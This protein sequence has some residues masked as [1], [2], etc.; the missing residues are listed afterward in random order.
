M[1]H[2]LLLAARTGETEVGPTARTAGC[3]PKPTLAGMCHRLLAQAREHVFLCN[4]SLIPSTPTE[5]ELFRRSLHRALDRN[6]AISLLGDLES[7]DVLDRREFLQ[8]LQHHGA[9]VRISTSP[10]NG[11]LIIDKLVAVSCNNSGADGQV[12][13]PIRSRTVI[14]S[15]QRLADITWRTSWNL[16]LV[17]ML[18][19]RDSEVSLEVLRLLNAGHKDDIGARLL[20]MSVRT[21]RRHV[22]DLIEALRANSRFEAG[23]RAASLGLV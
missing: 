10:P 23:A 19:R 1:K 7:L 4:G 3:Y 18:E 13:A 5:L 6:V 21:Y 20:G 17:S 14:T 15:L 8:E 11:M 12:C 16:E 9:D 22:A 2:A